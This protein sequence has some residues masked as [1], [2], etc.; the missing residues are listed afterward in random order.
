[1]NDKYTVS[2]KKLLDNPEVKPLIDK[3]LSS[4]PLYEPAHKIVYAYIPTREEL[5]KKILN[6]YKYREI[7]FETVGRFIDELEISMNEIM[8]YYN[9]LYK[10]IDMM[11]EL[12]NIFENV[13]IEELFDEQR[14]GSSKGNSKGSSEGSSK[15]TSESNNTSNATSES[16]TNSNVES[17][18]KNVESQTPQND[19]RTQNTEIDSV[20]YADKITW[21]HNNSNDSAT[22]TGSDTTKSST[23]SKVSNESTQ[24][25][26]GETSEETKGNTTHKLH[27]KGN[28]GVNTYAHDLLEFRE[29]FINIEQQIIN[30][31]RIRELFMQIW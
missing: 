5:N 17:Y 1:M 6:A 3:A 23:D 18:N 28:Q 4:Y 10:S 7:G 21:N 9:S 2:L 26:T 12:D 11:N 30:D 16:K 27:R 24:S 20:S 14:E 22:N 19:I 13:D 8:P 29:L 15:G 31:R 25:T